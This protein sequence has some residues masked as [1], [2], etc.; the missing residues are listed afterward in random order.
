MDQSDPANTHVGPSAIS[1]VISALEKYR[2]LHQRD[3][4]YQA[5]PE[6]H[7]KLRDHTDIKLV[8]RA[9][10]ATEPQRQVESQELKANG[11][12]SRM[13]LFISNLFAWLTYNIHRNIFPRSIT[14]MLIAASIRSRKRSTENSS[15]TPR[16]S[17]GSIINQH[18]TP[19]Q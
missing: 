19:R 7:Q 3:P 8:E 15:C 2:S 4:C 12:I 6:S 14:R 9:A 16:L 13:F 17:H 1:Q 18:G 10:R 5:C 11:A